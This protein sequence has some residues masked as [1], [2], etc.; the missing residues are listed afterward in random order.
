MGKKLLC[1]ILVSSVFTVWGD[2]TQAQVVG[3][4]NF[5]EGAGDSAI[6]RSGNGH[7][8]TI[9]NAQYEAGGFDGTGFAMRFMGQTAS[10][11]HVGTFD[12]VGPGI[13]LACWLKADNLDTPGNDPRMISKATGGNNDEHIFMLS[14]SRQS[15]VKVIRVRLRT[16]DGLAT[17]ELKGSTTDAT[18]VVDEWI[19]A[20]ATWDGSTIRIYKNGLEAGSLAKGGDAVYTDSSVNVAIGNQPL[21]TPDRPFEGLIDDVLIY[22]DALGPEELQSIM[23]SVS[24]GSAVKPSP[25][26]NETDV[27]RDAV[28]TWAPGEYALKHDVYFG[29]SWE[30]VNDATVAQPLGVLIGEGADVNQVDVGRLDFGQT[31][32]WR[33]DEVNG[34]PDFTVFPGE[35]WSF[36]VEPVSYPIADVTATASSFHAADMG[37]EKTSDG[38]GLDAVDQHSTLGTDMWLSGMGDA[39]P[40]IQY[41]FGRAYKLHQMLVWNSNQLIEAFVGLGAKDVIIETSLDGMEWTV[42]PGATLF[43]QAPGKA[44]YTANTSIDIGGVMAKHVKITINAGHGVSAQYGLSEVR[45]MFIP[46]WAREPRPADG[47]VTDSVDVVLGWRA[48]RDAAAHEVVYSSDLAAVEDGSAVAGITQESS[49]RPESIHYDATYYWQIN[50]VNEAEIPSRHAG[51]IWRFSTPEYLVVDDFEGYNDNCDRIFFAWED[52]FGHNGSEGIADC[53]VTAYNGNGTGSIVGHANAP[54]AEQTIVHSGK[55]SMPLEY[56]S[57]V[58]ETMLALEGQNWMVN[59]IQT[60]SLYF[61]G[62]LGNTGQLYLKI[63]NAKVLFD[64]NTTALSRPFWTQ[65]NV[66]L[67]ALGTDLSQVSTLT[68]GIEGATAP[69]IF[70]VDDIRLYAQALEAVTPQDPGT[71]DLVA[72]YAL[73]NNTQDGSG[74]GNHG[75]PV[76]VPMYAQ[77]VAGMGMDFDA[78]DDRVDLGPL[79]VIGS[80]ITLALWLNPESFLYDDTRVISKAISTA[81]NDHWWMVSTSGSGHLLRFRL[82][83]DEGANTTTLVAGSGGVAVGEWAHAA[84]VWDGSTMRIYQNLQEVGSVAKGGTAVAVDASVNAAIGNQPLGAGDKHWDGLIDEVRIYSRGLSEAELL[85]LGSQ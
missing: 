78:I 11:L 69:G 26:H 14:S 60:L 43:N 37:P 16:N 65:W 34:A 20:A 9:A 1:S 18:L 31:Y 53:E 19:H 4:W 75:T 15:G 50:E 44:D 35:L 46:T 45:F 73:E 68:I 32:H 29:A 10:R 61:Y 51:D 7:H 6:D 40:W 17:S 28:L 8:G 81:A 71:A 85:Y 33:V 72:Y 24:L 42:V 22:A 64:G 5:E 83:T 3:L 56:D 39:V 70:Y 76:G 66:A 58:S 49:F 54:F 55:Q 63:N 62:A 59:G 25:A 84:A 30:D 13:T 74:H 67:D 21:G 41:E 48:G 57:A 79:D 27:L 77:G 52:G 12:V 2:T 38:S 36:T 23:E 80:G 82:K 47:A